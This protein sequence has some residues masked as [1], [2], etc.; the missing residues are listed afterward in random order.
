MRL[1]KNDI[2]G[3]EM[4][5]NTRVGTSGW[6]YE[7]WVGPVYPLSLK[8]NKML[9][10]YIR[11]FST[12]EINSTFYR[13]PNYYNVLN[14]ARKTPD[15][16]K[17]SV[18][19]YRGITHDAKLNPSKF[20]NLL[21]LQMD[22]LKVLSSKIKGYLLQL[23]PS[24]SKKNKD[25]ARYLEGFFKFWDKNWPIEKLVV[26]FRN[27]SW[28][29]DDTFELLKEW[30]VSYCIVIEPLI[31]PIVKITNPKLAYIRFHG[32]GTNPWF[33]YNFKSDELADWKEKIKDVSLKAG[34]TLVYFNNHFSGNAVK[35]ALTLM[36]DLGL[37]HESL[38]N[39]RKMFSPARGQT[40]LGEFIK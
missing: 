19:I 25:D 40:S 34:D 35:N 7:D 32:F 29:Q 16:F 36:D 4:I 26:E 18:K 1:L 38:K 3:K 21:N 28:I 24:F 6:Y 10:F 20:G 15:D 30:G 17:F 13:I 14:W 33:N 31:P 11:L 12:C 37:P 2:Q 22:R 39:V 27:L 23:P 9:D 5:K 8:K